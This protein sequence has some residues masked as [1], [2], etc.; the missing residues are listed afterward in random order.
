MDTQ[1][2]ECVLRRLETHAHEVGTE[3]RIQSDQSGRKTLSF[4]TPMHDD[5]S[6]LVYFELCFAE[7]RKEDALF[8]IFATILPEI[9]D[10]LPKLEKMIAEWNLTTRIGAYGVYYPLDQMYFKHCF[11]LEEHMDVS[12]AENLI[13]NSLYLSYEEISSKYDAVV[14]I[15]T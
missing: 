6:G 9:A 3:V 2:K 5:G 7:C 4:F 10:A 8:Q 1:E 11:L 13:M 15:S 12:A 14:S